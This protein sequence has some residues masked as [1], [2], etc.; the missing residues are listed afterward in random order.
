MEKTKWIQHLGTGFRFVLE[1]VHFLR[2][3]CFQNVVCFQRSN[4]KTDMIRRTFDDFV[5]KSAEGPNSVNSNFGIKTK[6]KG[7]NWKK[8]WYILRNSYNLKFHINLHK[9]GKSEIFCIYFTMLRNFNSRTEYVLYFCRLPACMQYVFSRQLAIFPSKYPFQPHL[10]FSV[11]IWK[12]TV[13]KL[14]L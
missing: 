2:T 13:A 8:N 3:S 12:C 5:K 4:C 6:K 14:P 10:T 9:M 7:R 11:P 1:N